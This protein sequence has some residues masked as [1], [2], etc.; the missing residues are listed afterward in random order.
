MRGDLTSL[1]DADDIVTTRDGRQA[2]FLNRGGNHILGQLDVLHHGRVKA[3]LAE[4]HDWVDLDRT[5]LLEIHCGHAR[6][7]LAKYSISGR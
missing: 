5:L 1:S 4:A 6:E 2:V 3:G 7:L